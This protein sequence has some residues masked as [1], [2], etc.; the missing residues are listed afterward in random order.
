ML[1][2]KA[3]DSSAPSEPSEYVLD[4]EK[5]TIHSR[6]GHSVFTVF[7]KVAVR[8]QVSVGVAHRRQLSLEWIS[9]DQLPASERME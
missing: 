9:R 5:Q 7:D 3:R 6:N 4:E 8:I 2:P 1:A